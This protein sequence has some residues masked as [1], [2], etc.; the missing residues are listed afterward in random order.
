MTI[1]EKIHY[2]SLIF[3]K[4]AKLTAPNNHHLTVCF[5]L[6]ILCIYWMSRDDKKL[7]ERDV[8]NDTQRSLAGH[9][10]GVVARHPRAT[11]RQPLTFMFHA[12][13]VPCS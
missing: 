7:L 12:R 9:K 6:H 11:R 5:P 1:S 3:A 4:N 13:H 10:L 8:G 2:I